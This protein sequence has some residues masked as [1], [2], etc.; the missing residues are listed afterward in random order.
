MYRQINY[1]T[2]LNDEKIKG[3]LKHCAWRESTCLLF[4]LLQLLKLSCLLF[5]KQSGWKGWGRNIQTSGVMRGSLFLFARQIRFFRRHGPQNQ[6]PRAAGWVKTN[7]VGVKRQAQWGTEK[8]A[9]FSAPLDTVSAGRLRETVGPN[10]AVLFL[11]F[12][13]PYPLMNCVSSRLLKTILILKACLTGVF[14]TMEK[15]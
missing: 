6:T 14:H 4:G 11:N 1:G 12:E 8:T 9:R 7:Y 2:A 3:V 13:D 5:N 10:N 15:G